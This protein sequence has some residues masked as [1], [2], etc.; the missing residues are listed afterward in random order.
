MSFVMA[1]NMS[2]WKG[3]K[4][5]MMDWIVRPIH[6]W[7]ERPLPPQALL[8]VRWDTKAKAVRKGGKEE[9]K[10]AEKSMYERGGLS[11]SPNGIWCI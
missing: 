10:R 4:V 11:I 3:W 1:S 2:D 6:M 5:T 7:P 9:R 8:T